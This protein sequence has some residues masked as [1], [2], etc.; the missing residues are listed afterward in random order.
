MARVDFNL[1]YTL[2]MMV[3]LWPEGGIV[4]DGSLKIV[5][6]PA[7]SCD[8]LT[9]LSEIPVVKDSISTKRF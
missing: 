2:S 7:K 3:D 4:I 8:S 9:I 6:M 5:F 1:P